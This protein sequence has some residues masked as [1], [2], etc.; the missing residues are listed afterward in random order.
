MT[1]AEKLKDPRWQKKRLEIL[2]RDGFACRVCFD[3]TTT[4]HV[5]HKF[6]KRGANPWDYPDESLITL[7]AEC[8][9]DETTDIDRAI[10]ALCEVI[11]SKFLSHEIDRITKGFEKFQIIHEGEVCASSIEYALA[12]SKNLLDTYFKHLE[13]I[14]KERKD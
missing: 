12:D 9:K 10:H 3:T 2:Q 11:K 7:C 8:H 6:Y 5:H 1:Y 14:K 13:D 4:L